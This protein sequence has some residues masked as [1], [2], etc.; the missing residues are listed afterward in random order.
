MQGT[1]PLRERIEKRACFSIEGISYR[2][3]ETGRTS[4]TKVEP[5]KEVEEGTKPISVNLFPDTNVAEDDDDI[6]VEEN[7][8]PLKKKWRR[9]R[10]LQ[11]KWRRTRQKI[12]KTKKEREWRRKM[13]LKAKRL[14]RPPKE[15]E[16]AEAMEVEAQEEED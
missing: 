5:T 2:K 16:A 13:L 9:V 7:D 3:S 6:I 10:R 11:R 4:K 14:K 1:R 12:R 8:P 15:K